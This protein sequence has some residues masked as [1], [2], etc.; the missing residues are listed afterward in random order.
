MYF[1]RLRHKHQSEIVELENKITTE[2]ERL[3]K[4]HYQEVK[5]LKE[6]LH[7]IYAN[8]INKEKQFLQST[9]EEIVNEVTVVKYGP[10]RMQPE[11]DEP[12]K[13]IKE[14]CCDSLSSGDLDISIAELTD[15]ISADSDILYRKN[16][17]DNNEKID[18]YELKLCRES[19]HLVKRLLKLSDALETIRKCK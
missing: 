19:D 10:I 3:E 18:D 11:R 2:K 15:L 16:F 4:R 9:L 14:N 5:I 13:L 7:K 8:T 12:V 17:T 1:F 6:N